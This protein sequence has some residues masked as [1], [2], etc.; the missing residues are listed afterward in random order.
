MPYDLHI[1]KTYEC[2]DAVTLRVPA[3]WNC[4]PHDTAEGMWGC[5]EDEEETGTLWINVDYF[6]PGESTPEPEIDE[7][8]QM[9]EGVRRSFERDYPDVIESSVIPAK[10]GG[11]F[12][13]CHDNEEDG[14]A[15]RNFHYQFFIVHGAMHCSI[16]F[17]LVL[18]HSVLD[19]PE[20]QELIAI[21][22][23]E[24]RAARLEPFKREE[25]EEAERTLGPLH[26][27]NFGDIVRLTLPEVMSVS[28][29]GGADGTEPQWYGSVDRDGIHAGCWIRADESYL[30]NKSD[31]SP[32]SV[33]EENYEQF[34]RNWLGDDAE[35]CSFER[36][37]EGV[38]AREVYDDEDAGE[39]EDALR[40]HVWQFMHFIDGETCLFAILLMYRHDLRDH[41]LFKDL[42]TFLDREIP[43]AE[44]L[45]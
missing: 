35:K 30:L 36:H 31:Q 33:S 27:C 26:R 42:A 3:R 38:I 2:A 5:Y 23:R 17:N 10:G 21:I 43:R 41:P 32:T 11:L 39:S 40:K 13:R 37:P 20:I 15:L 16:G 8:L 22:D 28:F 4:G 24:I 29:H 44:F 6:S 18:P 12:Y 25:R 19:D 9:I 7:L 45:D 14:E 1:L 34:F